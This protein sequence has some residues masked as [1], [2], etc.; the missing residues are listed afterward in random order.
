MARLSYHPGHGGFVWTGTPEEAAAAEGDLSGWTRTTVS[1]PGTVRYYTASYNA[2]PL[3]NPWAA[4]HFWSIA[5]EAAQKVLAPFREQYEA[6]FALAGEPCAPLPEGRALAPFQWAGVRYALARP[7]VLIGDPM[8][9]GKTVQALAI[10]NATAPRRVLIICPAA[11]LFQ[12][13]DMIRAWVVPLHP[14]TPDGVFLISSSRHGVHPRARF[15]LVSY[16]RMRSAIGRALAAEEWD[17]TIL[18]EAHY[19]RNHGAQRT[20][21]VLGAWDDR[22]ADKWPGVVQRSKRIVALTGTPLVNR[23]RECYTLGR[24]LD[25]Q[26]LDFMSEDAFSA[27]LNPSTTIWVPDQTGVAKPRLIERVGRLPELRARL[28]CNFMVRRDKDKAAPQLPQKIYEVIELGNAETD[29]IARAERLLDIDPDRLD[30]IPVEQRGHIAALRKEM[31]IAMVPL[32][33]SYVEMLA[34]GSDPDE[35]F[36]LF[37]HHREV[38]AQLTTRLRAFR[39]VVITGS[40]SPL[41]R[42]DAIH[43]FMT[44]RRC[45]L[46]IGQMQAGGTGVDGLQTRASR[47]IFAEASWIPG[48]NEQCV[49]RLHRMGQTRSV[50]VDFLVAA[51]SLNARILGRAVEKLRVNHVALD[52]HDHSA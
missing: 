35:A 7:H 15:V 14:K 18:D 36:V 29:R 41:G 11:I 47:V 30:D 46:F 48:E 39:P 17:L 3:F 49:D 4:V 31:G 5:D 6:S 27:R 23:P 8:G 50:H 12:W 13:R 26:A 19:L 33:A 40:T 38:I 28:R 2:N 10:V 21:A 43:T 32:V 9:L 1:P 45:R 34:E 20:R 16:D 44:D 52:S 25:W 24:A 42:R 37:A 51:D 22:Q